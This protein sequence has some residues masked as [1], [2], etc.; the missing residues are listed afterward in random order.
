MICSSS[1]SSRG[2]LLDLMESQADGVLYAYG[3]GMG[4]EHQESPPYMLELARNDP[5]KKYE[6][7]HLDPSFRLYISQGAQGP[8][9]PHCMRSGDWKWSKQKVADVYL[10]QHKQWKNLTIRLISRAFPDV[11]DQEFCEGFKKYIQGKL[12]QSAEVFLG[13]HNACWADLWCSLGET[14]NQL[15]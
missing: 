7:I 13:V 15:R 3:S 12:S 8:N 10:A 6:M 11:S 5:K 1:T 4:V 14:F 2:S 9:Y